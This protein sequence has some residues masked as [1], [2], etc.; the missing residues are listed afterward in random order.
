MAWEWGYRWRWGREPWCPSG[1]SSKWRNGLE[2]PN[3][4]GG[5]VERVHGRPP[6]LPGLVLASR[7]LGISCP[8][9]WACS[10]HPCPGL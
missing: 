5:C 2:E 7:S 1:L 3:C 4:K 9:I 6:H 10:Q 8:G